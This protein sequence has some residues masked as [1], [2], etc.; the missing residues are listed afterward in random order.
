MHLESTT[1]WEQ[2]RQRFREIWGYNDFRAPQGEVVQCLLAGRD[3][4][5][6]MPTGGGKSICFQLPALLQRGLTLVVSPLVA[7]MENQVQELRERRVPAAVLHSQLGKSERRKVLWQIQQQQLRLLYLSPETLL[8]PA[9][10]NV[11][12]EPQVSIRA[13]VLDEAH[14][15]AQWGDSFRPAYRRL[16]MVREALLAHKPA[17]SR[18]AIAAF[19]ATA[20]PQT[21]QII[22]SVLQLQHPQQICVNPYRPNLALSV[23]TVWTPRGRRKRVH[24]FVQQ[25]RGESGLVYARTRRGTEALAEWLTQQGDRTVAYHAGLSPQERRRIEAAWLGGELPFVVCTSAFGMGINNS[26]VRWVMHFQAPA[27]LS[28]Y[29]QEVGRAGRDGQPAQALTLISEPTGWFDPTDRQ[30]GRYFAQRERSLQQLAHRLHRRIP[31]EGEIRAIAHQHTDG[32][33]VLAWLHRQGY[34]EWVGPFHYRLIAANPVGKQWRNR[35]NASAMAAYLA[36]PTCRWQAI[37]AAFGFAAEAKTLRCGTCDRCR[38]K[39][40]ST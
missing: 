15:L 11:L 23:Q 26:A 37:L 36:R 27:L 8:N 9:V 1:E 31:S 5:V 18:M 25:H 39:R 21:Q 19:T 3:A 13:L 2:V 12:C 29:V 38:A 20:D 34:V 14:C 10:W 40:R 30:M 17:G 22:Q 16:G 35:Q 32:E 6:V 28:E 4:L 33:L 7:L 24:Q